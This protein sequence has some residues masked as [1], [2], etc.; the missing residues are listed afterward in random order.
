MFNVDYPSV[1]TGLN[2]QDVFFSLLILLFVVI[3]CHTVHLSFVH[4]ELPEFATNSL[5]I[6]VNRL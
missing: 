1:S 2:D 5:N 6:V 3:C 4:L